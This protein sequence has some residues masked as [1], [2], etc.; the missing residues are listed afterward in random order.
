MNNNILNVTR[1]TF[2]EITKSRAFVGSLIVSFI[3]ACMAG[4]ST[5]VS[6]AEKNFIILDFGLGL[7]SIYALSLSIYFG[8]SMVFN[9]IENRT[10]Y[11]ILTRP[12]KRSQYILGKL[13][14]VA[15]SLAVII[16]SS[17]LLTF[18]FYTMM[19]GV[20]HLDFMMAPVGLIIEAILAV[21]VAMLMSLHA[22]KILSSIYTILVFIFGY[23]SEDLQKKV[24]SNEFVSLF[25]KFIKII[26]PPLGLINFKSMIVYEQNIDYSHALQSIL[27]LI[28]YLFTIIGLIVL[29]FERKD[30]D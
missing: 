19:G 27:C 24:Y 14:G 2:L 23:M 17:S 5:E 26:F 4:L 16:F 18:L 29:T 20:L 1:F 6:Y 25:I 21:S 28:F 9:D 13:F 8:T 11:C 10:L 22:N 30:L 15:S 7:T 3:I 12:V